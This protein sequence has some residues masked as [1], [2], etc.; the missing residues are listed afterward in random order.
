MKNISIQELTVIGIGIL[1][2]CFAISKLAFCKFNLQSDFLSASATL[3]AAV[4]A[5]K[6]FNS[7]KEQYQ[8]ELFERLKDRIHNLFNQ[9]ESNYNNYYELF[10]L[11]DS[12]PDRKSIH[13]QGST[14]QN[15]IDQLLSELD[16]YEKL[17]N[18]YKDI[19][20]ELVCEPSTAKNNLTDILKQL[21]PDYILNAHDEWVENIYQV[22]K[23]D[24]VY[25]LLITMK[26]FINDDLQ[27]II[28]KLIDE[29]KGR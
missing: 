2:S 22:L 21:N 13:I 5:L 19:E 1:G 24:E 12:H 27:K 8:T 6:M 17:I 11:N 29:Q 15:T 3:F 16:F 23:K 28:L 14:F 10:I 25:K 7:W 26:I 18:K 4:V 9:L 20:I